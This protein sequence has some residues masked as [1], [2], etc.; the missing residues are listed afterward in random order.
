MYFYV[1][2]DN[3]PGSRT[4]G[5]SKLKK[6]DVVKVFYAD[7]NK[8]Y[9]QACVRDGLSNNCRGTV[10]FISVRQ[11]ANAVDFAIAVHIAKDCATG[12]AG[13]VLCMVSGDKHFDIVKN[14]LGTMYD[15]ITV[16]RVESIEEGIMR[17]FL[18]DIDSLSSLQEMLDQM[19][20]LE[21]GEDTY[22]NIK[23]LFE[24]QEQPAALPSPRT[25]IPVL[26]VIKSLAN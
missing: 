16:N 1:D 2:G 14:E 12:V 6:E 3:G 7:N 18:L 24:E 19:Y 21:I 9:S 23:G 20:G 17:Y 15:K 11:G 8:H 25:R 22:L 4:V 5:L 10:E 13:K 26:Q